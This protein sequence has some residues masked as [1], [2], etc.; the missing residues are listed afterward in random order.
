MG[1]RGTFTVRAEL[2]T[3]SGEGHPAEAIGSL[4]QQNLFEDVKA[5]IVQV[6]YSFKF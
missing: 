2:M 3:Q 1:K 5:T 6:G 4:R